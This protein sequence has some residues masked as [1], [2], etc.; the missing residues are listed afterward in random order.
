MSN[1]TALQETC[2]NGFPSTRETVETVSEVL[3]ARHTPLKRGINES[4]S[5]ES[6][7]AMKYLGNIWANVGL[8][9]G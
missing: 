4:A 6:L 1:Q 2:F 9:Q 5:V 8:G 7:V 3:P